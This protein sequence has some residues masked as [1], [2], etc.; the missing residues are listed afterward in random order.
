M[1]VGHIWHLWDTCGL[2]YKDSYTWFHGTEGNLV[3]N[4]QGSFS[5]AHSLEVAE[6]KSNLS[7]ASH[8]LESPRWTAPIIHTNP[9]KFITR[10][11]ANRGITFSRNLR[12]LT[13]FFLWCLDTQSWWHDIV[14]IYWNLLCFL[15][16]YNLI[17][18]VSSVL[19]PLPFKDLSIHFRWLVIGVVHQ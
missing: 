19:C 7:P 13:F 2:C 15:L 18:L 14:F 4:T 3:R 6:L 8:A 5:E 12:E 17:I 11:P 16:E 10:P 1:I 9:H